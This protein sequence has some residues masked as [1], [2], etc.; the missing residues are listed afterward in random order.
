MSGAV[1]FMEEKGQNF[2][3]GTLELLAKYP[4]LN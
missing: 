3:T 4:T 1:A 2:F